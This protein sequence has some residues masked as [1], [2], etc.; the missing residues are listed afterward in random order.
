MNLFT[1]VKF[2]SLYLSF[3]SCDKFSHTLGPPF[4]QFAFSY[5]EIL[6]MR[7]CF[8]YVY[9]PCH[10]SPTFLI[11]LLIHAS[12]KEAAFWCTCTCPYDPCKT[13][14]K[15]TNQSTLIM[16]RNE[17]QIFSIAVRM[18]III[19]CYVHTD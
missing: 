3:L 16:V 12:L 6:K 4:F 13:N 14:V 15:H 19:G 8:Q 9:G 18:E 1:H 17:L 2:S 7:L 10:A 11:K 5:G